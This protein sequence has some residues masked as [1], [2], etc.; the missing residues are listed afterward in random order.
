MCRLRWAKTQSEGSGST[1][2]SPVVARMAVFNTIFSAGPAMIAMQRQPLTEP[3]FS[4]MALLACS[5]RSLCRPLFPTQH[6]ST[7]TP[8]HFF[9]VSSSSLLIPP[10]LFT[11]PTLIQYHP[12]RCLR[13]ALGPN[14]IVSLFESSPIR[15]PI[16]VKHG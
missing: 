9:S 7:L 10:D 2:L 8:L 1:G 14:V 15:P 12:R 11:S 13:L 16:P 4:R 3:P 6:A 5:A